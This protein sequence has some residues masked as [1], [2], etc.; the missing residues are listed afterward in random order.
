MYKK[1]NLLWQLIMAIQQHN[2]TQYNT[3]QHNTT[4]YNYITFSSSYYYR[5]W[6]LIHRTLQKPDSE[7]FLLLIFLPGFLGNN[8]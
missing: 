2:T 5:L 3:I 4:Q 7:N 8:I 6:D 1:N